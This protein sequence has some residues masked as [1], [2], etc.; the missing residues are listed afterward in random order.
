MVSSH[1]FIGRQ[2]LKSLQ[3]DNSIIILTANK[4]NATVVMDR[5]EYSNKFAD[6]ISKGGYCKVKKN[7]TLKTERKLSK[8]LAKIKIS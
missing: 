7:P 4:G 8:I 6:L 3:N 1:F 5:V 2:D